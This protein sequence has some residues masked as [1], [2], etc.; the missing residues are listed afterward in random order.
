MKEYA[1]LTQFTNGED[2]I[3]WLSGQG[4]TVDETLGTVIG[5]NSNVFTVQSMGIVGDST[6]TITAVMDFST[7][8]EGRIAYWRNE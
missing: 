7:E 5:T 1:L 3:T 4:L 6:T 2:F 8:S